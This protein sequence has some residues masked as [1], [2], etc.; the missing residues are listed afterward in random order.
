MTVFITGGSRGIGAATVLEAI[1]QGHDVAFTYLQ[2]QDEAEQVVR[3]ARELDPGRTCRA[4]QLDTRDSA[5][6]EAVGDRVLDDFDTVDAVIAN[7]GIYRSG[8]AAMLSDEEWHE[9]I[10]TNLTGTFFVCRQFLPAFIANGRGCFVMISSISQGG[11]AGL[12]SYAA[13]KSGLIGL[14]GALAREYG[15]RGIRSNVLVPGLFDTDMTAPM[16][17]AGRRFWESFC[18]LGRIG[19]LDEIAK[20]ILFLTS[21]AAG[22][23]NGAAI[24]IT[25]GLD[26]TP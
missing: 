18:P 1:G 9:V 16:P 23:I 5:A 7:A 13:S 26:W 10:D 6:V 17:E 14:S 12:V 19:T 25:G 20:T 15:R 8:L 2:R 22:F 24:P 21:D 3:R 4:Y 11:A